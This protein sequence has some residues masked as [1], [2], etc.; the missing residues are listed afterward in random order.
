MEV[1]KL[2]K[3]YRI[4]RRYDDDSLDVII[5]KVYIKKKWYEFWKDDEILY[6]G[7]NVNSIEWLKQNGYKILN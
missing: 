2:S 6:D 1:N 5:R 7:K 4:T 3:W